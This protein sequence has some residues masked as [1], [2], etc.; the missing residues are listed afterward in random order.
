M[1]NETNRIEQQTLK[2]GD[3]WHGLGSLVRLGLFIVAIGVAGMVAFVALLHV[4]EVI[5]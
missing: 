1:R 5:P 4:A 3:M 2:L